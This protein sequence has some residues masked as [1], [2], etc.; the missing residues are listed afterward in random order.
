[1]GTV[2]DAAAPAAIPVATEV[3]VAERTGLVVVEGTVQAMTVEA[4]GTTAWLFQVSM[5]KLTLSTVVLFVARAQLF[6]PICA[7]KRRENIG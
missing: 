6:P 3:M 2:V 7:A 5:F 1:M 4:V